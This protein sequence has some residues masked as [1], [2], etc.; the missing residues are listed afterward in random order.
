[1][2]LLTKWKSKIKFFH[3]HGSAS[4]FARVA[5]MKRSEIQSRGLN[6]EIHSLSRNDAGNAEILVCGGSDLI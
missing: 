1:M 2:A 5:R 3:A 4:L 6:N